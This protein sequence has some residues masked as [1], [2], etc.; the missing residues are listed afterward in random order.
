M[1]TKLRLDN[2]LVQHNYFDSRSKAQAAIASGLVKIDNVVISKA[3]FTVAPSAKIEVISQQDYVSRAAYKLLGAIEYFK[4][5]IKDLVILDVGASTGGFTEVLLQHDAKHII[6]VDVGH[7][8]LH[9]K[10]KDDKRVTL[11][12]GV[13]ARYL[14]A[15]SLPRDIDAAVIDVS[16]ISL[17]LI[18]PNILKLIKNAGFVIALIKP[19]F[20]VGKAGLDKN[21]LVKDQE[22][23]INIATELTAWLNEQAG[24][25]KAEFIYSPITGK[26]GNQE[27]LLYGQKDA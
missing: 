11:M 1:T 20:E 14:E 12:E 8:Q 2:W 5:N 16:F 27:F 23:A 18:L 10:L 26:D 7:S 21:G 19:Q 25:H 17:K 24:W 22:N 15:S 6:A 3:S 13:N 4:P 9:P